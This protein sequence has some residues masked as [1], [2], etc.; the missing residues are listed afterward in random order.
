MPFIAASIV[1]HTPLLL[2]TVGKEYHTQTK[3]TQRALTSIMHELH[4][5]NPEVLCI[6]HPHGPSLDQTFMI[7]SGSGLHTDF[8]EFGD[9]VTK[10]DWKPARIFCQLLTEIAED[11]GFP[12]KLSDEPLLSHDVALPLEFFRQGSATPT[13]L[14][15]GIPLLDR[16][17]LIH[18]GSM[19]AEAMH[20]STQ[21]IVLMVSAELSHHA[22][23][24][25]VGGLRPEGERY[26]QY[27]QKLFGKKKW[28]EQLLALDDELVT[29]ADSCGYGP[30]LVLAG[31]MGKKNLA[32]KKVS[33][34]HPFGIGLLT[35]IFHNA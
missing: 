26:D 33:Y 34:E 32:A 3:K 12:V 4:A 7:Q 19:L 5:A 24:A 15:I 9:L 11:Q 22:S 30:L 20:R 2:P 25:A 17:T 23:A 8:T 27:I 13:V 31:V 6:I 16:Q 1:P 29:L 28:A 21:R 18:W 35:A 10:S 14:P